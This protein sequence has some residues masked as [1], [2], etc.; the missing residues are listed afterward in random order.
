MF[1]LYP[2]NKFQK[3]LQKKINYFLHYLSFFLNCITFKNKY[4]CGD[5]F[6]K[7]ADSNF[8]NLSNKS[9]IIFSSLSEF[10]KIC[11]SKH[12]NKIW[13]F[14]NSDDVFDLRKSKMLDRIK[15]KKC[16][17]TNLIIKKKNYHHIPIGLENF[18]YSVFFFRYSDIYKNY[19]INKTIKYKFHS[20]KKNR[21]LFGFND[22]HKD[23]KNY[24]NY[25]KNNF[26]SD[27]TYGWNSYVY[28]KILINYKFVFCPRG[29]GY[30]THRVWESLYLKVVPIVIEDKFNIFF[31]N[32]NLPIVFLKKINELDHYSSNKLSKI[33]KRLYP[34]FNNQALDI[35]YWKKKILS[36]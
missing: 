35:Q 18:K 32:L 9:K 2:K 13:I 3:F 25:L 20:Y 5:F 1:F 31:K 10:N 34:K 16:F 27:Y 23:R 22:T 28:R 29:N 24:L 15:P 26:L 36:Q 4:L 17:S 11:K 33:Y 7:I 6:E 14:H 21:I 19:N 12:L 30:D 8:L